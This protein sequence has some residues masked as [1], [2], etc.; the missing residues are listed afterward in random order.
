MP[1]QTIPVMVRPSGSRCNLSCA[2]CYTGSSIEQQCPPMSDDLQTELV[3]QVEE[4]SHDPVYVFHG[5]EPLL[6]GV[7]WYRRMVNLQR[8]YHTRAAV[9]RIQTNGLLLDDE[10]LGFF[11]ASPWSVGISYNGQRSAL[12]AGHGQELRHRLLG[13]TRRAR[14]RGISLDVL[15]V[16]DAGNALEP[17]STLEL[18]SE[19]ASRVTFLPARRTDYAPGPE[20]YAWFLER[21]F[22]YAETDRSLVIGNLD[23]AREAWR[24]RLSDCQLAPWCMD[25]VVV[26]YNGDLVSCDWYAEPRHVLGSLAT[27]SIFEAW[28]H[29]D[30]ALRRQEATLLPAECHSCSAR[31]ACNGGCPV[32]RGPLGLNRY[33]QALK[34]TALRARRML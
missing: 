34:A 23:N 9:N 21:A 12:R 5:G 27:M 8:S 31:R 11:A 7:D 17:E 18:C 1:D 29:I 20:L 33:C 3:R 22:D 16:V 26:D 10:W 13:W 15:C 6:V 19:L 14:D 4:H 2:D 30:T 28:D 32:D 25:H 24:H